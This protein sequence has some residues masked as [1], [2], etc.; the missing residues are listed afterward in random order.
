MVN[1]LKQPKPLW[2]LHENTFIIFFHHS[3]GKWL[4][5]LSLLVKCG[6]LV[7]FV[8]IVTANDNYTV[9]DCENL[10]FPIQMILS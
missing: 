9:W 1:M 6:I 2:N 5:Y 8:T 3:E 7:V 10:L 4:G